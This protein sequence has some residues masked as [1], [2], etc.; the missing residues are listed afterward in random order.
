MNRA[1]KLIIML[2]LVFFTCFFLFIARHRLIDGDEGFYLMASR[3]VLEHKTP[4]LDFL[5]TQ[6]PLLPYAYGLWM[7]LFGISWFSARSFSAMLTTILGLLVYEHVCRETE[8]W[9]AG[10]LAVIVFAS[11]TLIFAWFPIVKTYSLTGVL[12]FGAYAILSRLTRAS[13][14]WLVA[15]AGMLYGL[16]VN[17]RSYDVGLVPLLLWW[18]F[19]HPETHNGIPRILWFLGGFA[20]GSVPSLYLLASFPDMFLFNNLGYHAIRSHGGLIGAW[21]NKLHIVRTVLFSTRDNGLQFSI[22]AVSS[23]VVIFVLRMRGDAPLL[24]FLIAFALGFISIL[25]T[26]SYAQYFCLCMP[27]LIVAAVCGTSDYLNS[28][29]PASPRW[30]ALLAGVA[31]LAFVAS[32]G[33]SVQRYLVTGD[34]VIGIEDTHDAPNWTLDKVSAVSKAIDELAAPNEKIA[35]F[36]PGYIFASKADPFP[37]FE[38]DSGWVTVNKLTGDQR[39]KYHVSARADIV[40]HFSSR[41]LRIVVLG[42]QGN[43]GFSDVSE[44]ARVLRT[45]GYTAVRTIGDTSIFVCCSRQ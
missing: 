20:I 10:A 2:V 14:Q 7:K 45:N 18:I 39:A 37:G 33:P 41:T 6:A 3:L 36:W 43:E 17:T 19:R 24:A 5:Y 40:D 32:S 27:F 29:R 9:T 35:S 23:F 34:S 4:Y 15:V 26:P 44:W 38:N 28:L 25:P 8:K 11:S 21:G 12:L 31:V 42:N 22:L 1:C 30:I 13:S 16:S